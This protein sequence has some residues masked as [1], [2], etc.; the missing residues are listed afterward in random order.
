MLRLTTQYDRMTVRQVFYQLEVA[1]VVEKTER[2]YRDVQKQVLLMRREGLLPYSFITDGTRRRRKPSTFADASDYVTTAASQYR[3]DLWRGHHERVEVWLEKDGLADIVSDVTDRWDVSLMV[4]RG[5]SSET[6]LHDADV[7]HLKDGRDRDIGTYVYTLY[8]YDAGGERSHEQVRGALEL[9]GVCQV[10]RL[11]VTPEQIREWD[12][13][14]R[15]AKPSDPEAH[16]WGDTPCVE[17]DA[18]DP[19]TLRGLVEEAV[20]R[21]VDRDAWDAGQAIEEDERHALLQVA[22]DFGS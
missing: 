7:R 22:R 15:P 13:P 6:F 8:D 5:S 18:I 17:L 4:S 12:L 16:R 21:H 2:G 20:L 19:D 3:R 11:A 10:E 9:D 14:S 1:E